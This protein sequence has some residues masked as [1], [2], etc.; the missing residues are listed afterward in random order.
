MVAQ[1]DA[2]EKTQQKFPFNNLTGTVEATNRIY[3]NQ[4]T[5]LEIAGTIDR[6][7]Q[8]MLRNV[9][10]SEA[11]D[12]NP[13]YDTIPAIVYSNTVDSQHTAFKPLFTNPETDGVNVKG[14]HRKATTKQASMQMRLNLTVKIDL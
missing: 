7:G 3:D 2:L 1:Q 11:S 5:F 12:T 10:N 9:R 8:S 4:N 13:A 6:M 14:I